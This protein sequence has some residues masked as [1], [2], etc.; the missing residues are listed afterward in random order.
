M[1]LKIT[2]KEGRLLL[3]EYVKENFAGKNGI[4]LLAI[5]T[6]GFVTMALGLFVVLVPV[7]YALGGIALYREHNWQFWCV[8]CSIMRARLFRFS[9]TGWRGEAFSRAFRDGRRGED[10]HTHTHVHNARR[11]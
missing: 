10:A 11:D 1:S 7:T 2:P 5:A 4:F 8:E 6:L 3:E 9:S